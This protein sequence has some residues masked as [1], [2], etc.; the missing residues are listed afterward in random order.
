[1]AERARQF[2][3]LNRSVGSRV[4][5]NN[6]QEDIVSACS[7]VAHISG[8]VLTSIYAFFFLWYSGDP[9]VTRRSYAC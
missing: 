8:F 3:G 6:R 5:R 7:R 1:M 2:I 4:H 9:R